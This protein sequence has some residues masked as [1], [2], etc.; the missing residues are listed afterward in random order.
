V[1]D[2]KQGEKL[3]PVKKEL[4]VVG[5]LLMKCVGELRDEIGPLLKVDGTL[6]ELFEID[7]AS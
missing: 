7:K 2:G 6:A 3:A 1:G 5:L 4:K